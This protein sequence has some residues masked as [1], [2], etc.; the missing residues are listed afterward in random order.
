LVILA[1]TFRNVATKIPPSFLALIRPVQFL[2]RICDQNFQMTDELS[3][4]IQVVLAF[5]ELNT[6]LDW[7]KAASK[8]ND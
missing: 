6:L 2:G 1:W 8:R 5:D 7:R 3:N 4:I